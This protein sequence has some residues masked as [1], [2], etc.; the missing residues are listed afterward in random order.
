VEETF[1]PGLKGDRTP[2][3][4]LEKVDGGGVATERKLSRRIGGRTRVS[5][6]T[7]KLSGYCPKLGSE[8][9][10]CVRGQQWGEALG[11]RRENRF[12]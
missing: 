2:E 3:A 6:P 11:H 5:V 7:A 9:W 12:R 4:A 1:V 10:H 8:V